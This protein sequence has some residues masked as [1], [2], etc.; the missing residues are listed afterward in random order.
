MKRPATFA[1]LVLFTAAAQADPETYVIDAHRT[2]SLFSYRSLGFDTRTHRFE[3]ISGTLVIDR[4]ART[5]RAD[6]RIDV[7][8]VDTGAASLN[9]TLLGADFFDSTNHPAITFRSTRMVLDGEHPT[10]SGDLSIKG[11]TRRV[12]LALRSFRCAADETFKA[13]VCL[14]QASVTI[15]RSDFNMRK[16]AFL[17]GDEVRLALALRAVKD[18]PAL[19]LARSDP[20]R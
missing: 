11:V 15:R 10:L 7:S 5:G 16:Y 3:R 18:A 12:T 1:A 13:D 9:E 6:V 2:S 19:Q 20:V 14:A 4:A 8:S 17:V